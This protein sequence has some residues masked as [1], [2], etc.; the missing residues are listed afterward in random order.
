[1]ISDIFLVTGF[2]L[3]NPILAIFIKDNIVGGTI[4]MAS[5]AAT[6]FMLVKCSIQLPFSK[7]VD[8]H[9]H[10][11]N[12]LIVGTFLI[13]ITPFIYMFAENIKT[14]FFAQVIHGIGSGLV[15]PTWLGLWSTHL[16]KKH[17]SFEWS[18]YSTLV[19]LGSAGAALI[20]GILSE[21]IGFKYTFFFVFVLA[22]VGSFILFALQKKDKIL[23]KAKFTHYQKKRRSLNISQ[24][25]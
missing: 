3:T 19:T 5:L 11:V 17:E 14:V 8:K 6:I 21:S 20:G 25:S 9:D 1:M 13:S 4:F 18:L 16:D 22:M 24:G 23:P 10:K 7:Y 12:W 15:Y 2:G